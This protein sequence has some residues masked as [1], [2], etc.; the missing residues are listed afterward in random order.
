MKKVIIIGGGAAGFF[1]ASNLV[2]DQNIEILMLE[3]G[4]KPLAKVKV[5]G[6][7]RCNVTHHCFEPSELIKYYPRGGKRLLPVFKRF[8]PKDTFAWFESRNVKLKIESDNRVFPQSNDSQTIVDCLR[9]VL[10]AKNVKL[11]LQQ[12]VISISNKDR[13]WEVST[14]SGDVFL[15][16]ELI[17]TTGGDQHFWEELHKLG[18]NI[19]AP[20][21]SLFTFKITDDRLLDLPGISFDQVKVK[22]V[23]DKLETSGPMLITHW[24]LSGPAI[25]KLS[26]WGARVL[27]QKNY[28]FSIHINFAPHFSNEQLKLEFEKI[29]KEE[30]K[31]TVLKYPKFDLKSR[32]WERLCTICGIE[33]DQRW[34]DLSKKQFNKLLTEINQGEYKVS[35]KSTFKEEFVT[36]G[37]IDLDEVDFSGMFSK[38]Y[39][40][41]YFAGEVLDIDALTGG[42]N[43]QAAW[44]TSWVA[45][46][47]ILSKH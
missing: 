8:Q 7:G 43:F 26:A 38:K 40:S 46:Q 28:S 13:L 15:A 1:S 45:S 3:K 25:L 23:G 17:V 9:N 47:H 27:A 33:P 4:T 34:I 5:S 39:P 29:I 36:A 31:R 10:N 11:Q 24:G 44:S 35:G 12:H 16:D 14:K 37:G 20:L 32:F 6:G 21:P 30:G 2:S 41:L 22:L 42:F 19:I 18:L